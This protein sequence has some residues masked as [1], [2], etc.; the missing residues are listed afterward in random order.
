[1]KGEKAANDYYNDCN[2]YTDTV[3]VCNDGAK[4]GADTGVAGGYKAET[5]DADAGDP[6]Q[7]W[8]TEESPICLFDLCPNRGSLQCLSYMCANHC[9]YKGTELCP[10]HGSVL[11]AGLA[12][13]TLEIARKFRAPRRPGK[14]C[15]MLQQQRRQI[16]H[17][18]IKTAMKAPSS[19]SGN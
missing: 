6:L 9:P 4:G 12:N 18:A 10:R 15:Q 5:G 3:M 11:P 8:H 17:L 14:V 16:K 13:N 2:V 1:M 19:F 7:P